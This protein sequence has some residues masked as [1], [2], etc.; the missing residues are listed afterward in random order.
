MKSNEQKNAAGSPDII[1]C[2]RCGAEFASIEGIKI[3]HGM[4]FQKVRCPVCCNDIRSM[5]PYTVAHGAAFAVALGTL[6]SG[7]GIKPVSVGDGYALYSPAAKRG[8]EQASGRH[9]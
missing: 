3:A 4:V 9:E 1:R 6:L 2:W 8:G 5:R 7:S